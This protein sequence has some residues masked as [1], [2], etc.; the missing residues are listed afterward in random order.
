MTIMELEEL[1]NLW[2]SLDER[3]N[4]Q[5]KLKESILKEIMQSKTNRTVSKLI[6]YEIRSICAL[7]IAI[8]LCI[9]IIDRVRSVFFG[10]VTMIFTAIFSFIHL[11][12][13]IFKLHGLTKV[14]FSQSLNDSI[15]YINKY[16]I[17]IK[18]EKIASFI[19]IPIFGILLILTYSESKVPVWRWTFMVCTLLLATL[20]TYWGFKRIY[21][22]NITSIQKSLEELKELEEE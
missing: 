14:D 2:T 8:P 9:F 18:W 12:W 4:K 22:K 1:K 10:D 5:E 11:I 21:D 17:H 15:H 6:N 16:N 19:Y 7:L 3:L 13:E 20:F